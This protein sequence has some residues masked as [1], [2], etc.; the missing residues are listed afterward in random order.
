MNL[1]K[2]VKCEFAHCDAKVYKS[3][4]Y[5]LKYSSIDEAT[6]EQV[7]NKM[8]ICSSCMKTLEEMKNGKKEKGHE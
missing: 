4:S 6:G 2:K 7:I 3:K 5:T 1:F 8:T